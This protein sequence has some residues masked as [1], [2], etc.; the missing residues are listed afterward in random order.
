M[1]SLLYLLTIWCQVLKEVLDRQGGRVHFF[2]R[3]TNIDRVLT[4]FQA[5]SLYSKM[6]VAG[7]QAESYNRVRSIKTR[8]NIVCG[9]DR[10]KPYSTSCWPGAHFMGKCH[11]CWAPQVERWP[12][13]G[14]GDD[15]RKRCHD[16]SSHLSLG[17]KFEDWKYWNSWKFQVLGRGGGE[18]WRWQN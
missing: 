9:G 16:K 5:Y 4:I 1:Y 13:R 8:V 17:G 2:Y 6:G 11:L 15:S 3:S 10:G 14:C 7:R 12:V 18:S